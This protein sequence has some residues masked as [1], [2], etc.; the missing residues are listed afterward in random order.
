MKIKINPLG[1]HRIEQ[2]FIIRY[3]AWGIKQKKPK[4]SLDLFSYVQTNQFAPYCLL[5]TSSPC[6]E[7]GSV[8]MYSCSL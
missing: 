1:V 4:T 5:E 3:E 6:A 7:L 8:V 2:L